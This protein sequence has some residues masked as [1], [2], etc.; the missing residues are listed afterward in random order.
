MIKL[1]GKPSSNVY[2]ICEFSNY[3]KLCDLSEESIPFIKRK[4]EKTQI[5]QN[6][7][8]YARVKRTNYN[9]PADGA[10]LNEGLQPQTKFWVHPPPEGSNGVAQMHSHM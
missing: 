10:N 9:L 2:K 3:S 6:T 7:I 4:K 8:L 5:P 1:N